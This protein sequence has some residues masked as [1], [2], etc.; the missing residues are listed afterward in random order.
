MEANKAQ[1]RTRRCPHVGRRRESAIPLR[2]ANKTARV[3]RAVET[4]ETV[5]VFDEQAA[6]I[7]ILGEP[8]IDPSLG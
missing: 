7:H 6:N 3:A 4:Y 8:Q 5:F 1:G 2:V